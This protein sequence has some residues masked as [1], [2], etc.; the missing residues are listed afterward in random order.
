LRIYGMYNEYSNDERKQMKSIVEIPGVMVATV[1]DERIV[2]YAFS[3][4]ASYAGYFGDDIIVVEGDQLESDEFFE[5]VRDSLSTTL[6]EKSTYFSAEW[7][8]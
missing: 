7:S 2:G 3:P 5:M 8:E 4:H 1:V 6:D